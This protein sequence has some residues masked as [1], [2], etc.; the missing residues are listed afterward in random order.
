MGLLR[1]EG[2]CSECIK[3]LDLKDHLI[4]DHGLK[5]FSN[6]ADSSAE[7]GETAL[8]FG[9]FPFFSQHLISGLEQRLSGFQFL[10]RSFVFIWSKQR[11]Y[12]RGLVDDTFRP[13]GVELRVWC[14]V[15]DDKPIASRALAR[16]VITTADKCKCVSVS[17]IS[18]PL[19]IQH[20]RDDTKLHSTSVPS[21]SVY[22][23]I[24]MNS[25]SHEPF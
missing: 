24:R 11:L 2:G 17:R 7:T 5:L 12:E 4:D 1:S 6:I 10:D 9:L 14:I 23:N 15:L 21:K 18:I 13:A 16:A 25:L 8:E 20:Y 19:Q 22:L 3:F